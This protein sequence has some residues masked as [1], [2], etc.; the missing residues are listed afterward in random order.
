[1]DYFTKFLRPATTTEAKSPVADYLSEL[2]KSWTIV[3]DTLLHPD[4]RQ[5]TRGI[6][7]TDVPANLRAMVD[8]LVWESSRTD[9]DTTGACLEYLLKNDVLFTLVR[10]SENDR[11]SGVHGEVLRAISNMVVLLDEHFLVHSAVHRAIIRLL[12]S[13]VGDEIEEKVDGKAKPMGA[14]GVTSKSQPSDLEVDLVDLLCILCSRIRAYPDLLMIFFHDRNWFSSQPLAAVDEEAEDEDEEDEDILARATTARPPSPK[15]PSITSSDG[16]EPANVPPRKTQ[17]EFLIFNYLL[18]FVHREG[19]IGDFSRAGLLFLMDIAMTAGGGASSAKETVGNTE[20]S[21]DLS[22][23]AALALAEYILDGDFAEVL[24][25]GLAA[26]YSLLPTKLYVRRDSAPEGGQPGTGMVLGGVSEEERQ[27]V[28]DEELERAQM[29]GLEVSTNPDFRT[30]LD[31]FLKLLEFLQDVLR[32]NEPVPRE[33]LEGSLDPSVL[34][35]SAIVQ[36]ILDAFRSIFLQNVLYP[37]ILECSALD[38]SAVAV[39]SY[40]DIMLQT[41]EDERLSDSLIEFLMSEEDD[42]DQPKFGHR[43]NATLALTPKEKKINRRKSRAMLLLELEAPN[44]KKPSSYLTSLGRFTLK[45]LILSGLKSSSQPSGIVALKLLRS[46]LTRHCRLAVKGLLTVAQDPHATSFPRPSLMYPDALMPAASTFGGDD[47]FAYPGGADKST[48]SNLMLSMMLN[49]L[50]VQPGTS[51]M[52]HEHELDLY[53]TL[54]SRVD[55]SQEDAFSTGYDHYLEDAM[56]TVQGE[57]CFLDETHSTGEG[58]SVKHRLL[59]SDPLLSVL[60]RSLRLFFSHTPAYNVALTGAIASLAACPHRS[61]AGWLT[62]ASTTEDAVEWPADSSFMTNADDDEDDRSVDFEVDERLSSGV[63]KRPKRNLNDI[64]SL[65]VVYTILSG[66]V[67]Q[68]D[69]YRRLVNNFDKYL[70]ERRQ[71]LLFT[72]NLNDALSLVLDLST[73]AP[74]ATA[75][76]IPIIVQPQ[77]QP[78]LATSQAKPAK[79]NISSLVSFLTPRKGRPTSRSTSPPPDPVT[80]KP[81]GGGL[82]P[83]KAVPVSPFTPHYRQTGSIDLQPYVAPPP[84]AGPWSPAPKK[85]K[86][87]SLATSVYTEERDVFTAT[88]NASASMYGD[89]DRDE[90]DEDEIHIERKA[91]A[92]VTLSQL[93]DNVVILEESIKELAAIAQVRRSM[94]IDSISYF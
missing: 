21:H 75:P 50:F 86:G 58:S 80:P 42:V 67:S 79:S 5:L 41:L 47:T 34:V 30:R 23:D 88:P 68:L 81:K 69:R 18:R 16:S 62:Y 46:L 66:L 85:R 43:R 9:E 56:S 84:A 26:V 65:P 77:P 40:I 3:K 22:A 61:M 82:Q 73:E 53:F 71:G 1:M 91:A 27:V 33:D 38:G 83:P 14:A 44:Q 89:R 25:A 90:E 52:E 36:S 48:A 15:A 20:I 55:P 92:R 59:P 31:H 57:S 2:H 76:K 10:L 29:M 13:C 24:G 32:K 45:D 74:G 6:Q 8:N 37:S 4:E 49:P 35:G 7:S 19:S 72:E 93:L 78:T 64:S 12:R 11:P 54:V 28:E 60:L 70:L 87:S 51:Y 39:M 94:G 17:Y 63:K